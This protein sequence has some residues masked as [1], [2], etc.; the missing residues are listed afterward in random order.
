MGS[1]L[2]LFPIKVFKDYY[3]KTDDLKINLFPKLEKVFKDTVENNN[4]F[5]KD[6]TLCSYQENS[7]LHT[8]FPAETSEVVEFVE[9][10]AKEYWKECNYSDSLTPYVMQMWANRT[11]TGGWVRCHLHGN[12]PFTAVLYVD[13]S[14]EQG[15]LFLENPLD[16]VL[17]NQPI[18]PNV[19]YPMGE[20]ISVNNGDFIMFPGFL[21]HSVLPNNTD[22]DRL[23]L[24]FNIGCRGN[25]WASQWN[26]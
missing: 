5:M 16:M 4:P 10:A 15:N 22:R 14:P 23:I 9:A 12:M 7:Y 21:R 8:M 17:M 20:E 26:S 3:S 25:Y 11:P 6:G 18:S 19:K 1:S 13:A 24:A 2:S